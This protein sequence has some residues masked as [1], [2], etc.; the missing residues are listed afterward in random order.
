[1]RVQEALIFKEN[2]S[3]IRELIDQVVKVDN[4]LYQINR[5]KKGLN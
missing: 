3:T 4:K 2:V 1:M 5:A